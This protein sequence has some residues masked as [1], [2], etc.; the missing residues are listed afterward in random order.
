MQRSRISN[1]ASIAQ[2]RNIQGIVGPENMRAAYFLGRTDFL[3]LVAGGV[4]VVPPRGVR[5]VADVAYMTGYT[6]EAIARANGIA[7]TASVAPGRSLHL[8]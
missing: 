8:P 7:T 5:S 4:Y 1:Y 6:A 2:A 3:G